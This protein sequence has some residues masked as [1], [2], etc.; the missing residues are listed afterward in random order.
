MHWG[1]WWFL[2]WGFREL[3]L[4]LR[5]N[6][7]MGLLFFILEFGMGLGVDPRGNILFFR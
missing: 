2:L 1:L 3:Y 4:Y 7:I 5:E 6:W